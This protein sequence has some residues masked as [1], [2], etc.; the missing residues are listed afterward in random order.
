VVL[1]IKIEA[2]VGLVDPY[3]RDKIINN[4]AAQRWNKGNKGRDLPFK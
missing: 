2:A 3:P 1:Y 4:Q